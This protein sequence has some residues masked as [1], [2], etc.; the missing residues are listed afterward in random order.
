MV[1]RVRVKISVNDKS[2]ETSAL[3]NSGYETE[4]PQILIPIPL[5]KILNIWPS[6]NVYESTYETAGGPLRVWICRKNCK[7]K[8]ITSDR[9]SKEI[10]AVLVI[11]PIADEV[12][13]SDQAISEL[14]I[15]LE[16]VGKG[17]W[18]F[19]DEPIDKVRR[20]EPPRYWKE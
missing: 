12:L 13:L 8:V 10:D 19:R 20:S 5:A 3:L 4:M 2:V 18:R 16:D 15:A 1:V 6:S 11:S 17:L 14:E 9:E 7:V